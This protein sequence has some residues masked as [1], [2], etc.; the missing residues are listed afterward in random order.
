VG[1]LATRPRASGAKIRHA[2]RTAG[3]RDPST[4]KL[5]DQHLY[6][7]EKAVR[8]FATYCSKTH[9][10]QFGAVHDRHTKGGQLFMS[11][12]WRDTVSIGSSIVAILISLGAASFTYLQWHDMHMQLLLSMKPSVDF[13]TEDDTE[14]PP[15]GIAIMNE[16][17]APARVVSIV[18]YVDRKPVRDVS[19]AVE[20]GKFDCSKVKYF[21]YEADDTMAVGERH[22]IISY[23]KKHKSK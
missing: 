4:I 11:V 12:N 13:E 18:Y 23:L 7:S 20:Y 22:F 17:P 16:G 3:H 2:E 14:D 15:V 19:E 10:A 9:S 6:N 8:F 21:D 1:V 5:Y